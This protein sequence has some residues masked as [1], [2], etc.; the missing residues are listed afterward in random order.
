[1]QLFDHAQFVRQ[2]REHR[3]AQRAVTF[4]CAGKTQLPQIRKRGFAFRH[5]KFREDGFV[6]RELEMAALRDVQRR[7]QPFR[8]IR[9]QLFAFPPPI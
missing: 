3:G 5:R 2:P 4:L 8:M 9:E 7:A 6:Q 1:M